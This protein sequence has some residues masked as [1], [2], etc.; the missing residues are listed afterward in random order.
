MRHVSSLFVTFGLLFCSASHAVPII[1][2]LN[3]TLDAY[4]TDNFNFDGAN[5]E[6]I[7]EFNDA[8]QIP[9]QV[10]EAPSFGFVN[11]E[12]TPSSTEI[13]ITNRPGSAPDVSTSL[14]SAVPAFRVINFFPPNADSSEN[15]RINFDSR[16][17]SIGTDDFHLGGIELEFG[18]QTTFPGT[19]QTSLPLSLDEATFS[20]LPTIRDNKISLLYTSTNASIQVSGGTA[21]VPEPSSILLMATG[22]AITERLQALT[23]VHNG[24]MQTGY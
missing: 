17:F 5:F 12:Y 23:N 14:N 21:P 20:S 24:W 19:G 10:L 4:N 22:G 18:N 2:E 13:N 8:A 3:A 1:Y 16:P 15:D 6:L 11:T 9:T 7:L